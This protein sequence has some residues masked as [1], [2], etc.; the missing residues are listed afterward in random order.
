MRTAPFLR[1]RQILYALALFS[2]LGPFCQSARAQDPLNQIGAPTFSTTLPVELGSVNVSNGNLH[3]EIPLGSFPQ[4]G[5]R[6]LSASLLYDSRIWKVDS[7]SKWQPTNVPGGLGG[8]RVVTSATAQ[9]TGIFYT[10]FS[11]QCSGG[12][13]SWTRYDNFSWVQPDGSVRTFR[14]AI[15]I[16]DP[17]GC[18]GGSKNLPAYADDASG[19]RLRGTA[20]AGQAFFRVDAP[21]GTMAASLTYYPQSGVTTQG[22]PED[23]NGNFFSHVSTNSDAID[24]LGRT[25]I[26]QTGCVGAYFCYDILNSQNSTSR[27]QFNPIAVPVNTAFG[28]TGITENSSSIQPLQSV[29]LPDGSSYQ[30][31]YDSGTTPGHYG[32]LTGITLPTGA[33]INYTY[34]NF[35]DANKTHNMWMTSRTA[36]GGT[37]TYTPAVLTTCATGQVGCQQK[38][39]F[40]TPSSDNTVYT[41][42]L[43]NG[44]WRSQIDSYSG[45]V[46]P[47]NLVATTANVWDFSQACSPAPCTGASR[48]RIS[49]TTT[50][51]PTPGGGSI[52]KKTEMAYAGLFFTN[53]ASIKEWKFYAGASPT[54]PGTPDRET[55]F[56]YIVADAYT[57][58][59]TGANILD[60][61]LTKTI[62]D[63]SG[64]PIA[65]TNFSYDDSESLV[66]SVPATGI[67][68]HDDASFGL[69]NPVR[70]NLTQAKQCTVLPSCS[71][72]L[73]TKMTYDTTGQV[74]STQDP[75]GNTTTLSYA[76]NFFIDNGANPP[77]T[78]APSAPTNAYRTSVTA[79]LIGASTFGHYYGSGKL[80]LAKDQD[81][82]DSY[83][84]F[85]DPLDRLTHNFGPISPGGSRPWALTSYATS[86]TQEDTYVGIQDASPSS[87]CSSCMH[88]QIQLDGLGRV[89]T[90][91]LVSDPDGASSVTASY[92]SSG[93][94]SSV[95]HAARA[96]AG[97]TDGLEVPAYDGLDRVIKVTHPDASYSQQLYGTAV[98]GT[99]L[100]GLTSQLCPSATNGLGFPILA[101][102]EA[103]KKRETWT[104]GFG[105][106]I[107]TDEPDSSGSLVYATCYLYNAMGNLTRV[108]QKGGTTDPTQW[109][110]RTF[111][112]D[113]LS[114]LTQS[115]NPES[116]TINYTYDAN[117]NLLTKTAPKPNQTGSATVITTYT[118]D[119]L[120]R[121]THKSF[122][123]STT[124]AA[125]YV[126][127]GA[128]AP[129]G[130]T[131][132]TLTITNGVGRRTSMCD[133]AG[134]EAWS[135]DTMG[136]VTADRRTTNGLSNTFSYTYNLD[137]SP[138]TEVHP[139]NALTINFQQGAAGRL[140]SESSADANY[141]YNV[142]Y[143]PNGSICY[144]NAAWGNTFTHIWTFNNRLQPA[145]IQ[146]YGTGHGASSPLCSAST[147]GVG[148]T[149]DLS[150][151]Y[152]D[153]NG[154]NNGNVASITP[155]ADTDSAQS[156]TYDSLNRLV[157]AQTAGT[158]QPAF[159]GDT[160]YLQECW[161]E[162][163]S[164]DPWG[165]LVSIIPSSSSLYTG[166]SQESG[167]NLTGYIGTN[168]RILPAAGYTYDS[169]GNM[170]SA[171]PTGTNYTYDAENHLLTAGGVTYTYDGDGK[172]VK[173]S[174]GKIYWYGTQ[175]AP[176]IE[177]DLSGNFQY[178]HIYFNG[179]HVSREEAND[180]VDHYGLD[181]LGNVRFVYGYNGVTSTWD[182]SDYYPFGAE[183]VVQANSNNQ[184]KFTG[185]ERDSESGLNHTHFRQYSST[186]GRWTSP[187]PLAGSIG[188]PQSLNLYTYVLSN[189]LNL[190]DPF[191][192]FCMWDDHHRDD[193]PKD[194]GAS[195]R[196]CKDQGG[197][198]RDPGGSDGPAFGGFS[199]ACE[200]ARFVDAMQGD[201][202]AIGTNS[203][204]ICEADY[205]T[206]LYK[207]LKHHS[208]GGSTKWLQTKVFF[209]ALGN[210]W[211]YVLQ[212]DC[213]ARFVQ[214]I[215]GDYMSGA[216]APSADDVIRKGSDTAAIAYQT[217][218]G[219]VV[220]LRSSI[221][222]GILSTG[223]KWS[224]L[225]A[226]GEFIHS[227]GKSLKEEVEE[228]NT[229]ACQA[230]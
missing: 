193:D 41:F 210:N 184:Y 40:T 159:S 163:Y 85:L 73:L 152:V 8:W 1:V 207:H 13:S 121:L 7:S 104:D 125:T 211:N 78:Y 59:Y 63:T 34:T 208:G 31:S 108:D 191:G 65:Q 229:G 76:D 198:W 201:T 51:L 185:K 80:A 133:A 5:G 115:V 151:S 131:P 17:A 218:K 199:D 192:L 90:K 209:Q 146:L 70:G 135:Y 212:H 42:I 158:N 173:K 50:T 72:F 195:K 156:F 45:A 116:G 64:N 119:A 109:R 219:L 130:C 26:K 99:G 154:H 24:T 49:R 162:Q 111:T 81:N 181:A 95:S 16:T 178:R 56:T 134:S 177:T 169:A 143:A 144:M 9:G 55:D 74:L 196:D 32:L 21:D 71:S 101:V 29:V 126:Y 168:N 27:F 44:A 82:A 103:G 189:P 18:A 10:P 67:A 113:S 161:A 22:F 61:V 35:Q 140:I 180:W 58:L 145:R 175:G 127:D 149:V 174:S 3:L 124:P 166:C 53:L 102:D 14:S 69:T 118:Y 224:G 148:S 155:N 89:V 215:A 93:R 6:S 79:P 172:R 114:R 20:D 206:R 11:A 33:Q 87:S 136:R 100:G 171:P 220:P 138:L 170:I 221:F 157:T 54:F 186:F 216:G 2:L 25:P 129:T 77:P 94:V 91:T 106:I 153:A 222:R 165:N 176:A 179:L 48:I 141:A 36:G 52:T 197:N 86:E 213:A 43:N 60:R 28:Q 37:S 187:D 84:H 137:G 200:W 110:T 128:A 68:H 47:A 142:H 112:Y 12:T 132:P 75:N 190:V 167:F 228:V 38:V 97:P 203:D 204:F 39:T 227:E 225:V 183:R 226:V 164:Y 182:L 98:T 117:S 92:D 19:Y 96:T 205:K 88:D 217:T 139:I 105:G 4:R 230:W 194:G 123:D 83:V 223:E 15:I 120:N 214:R 122:N 66:N 107:E 46:A 188:N 160:G 23:T 150:Y 62:K 202:Y 30:F 147:D 57:N